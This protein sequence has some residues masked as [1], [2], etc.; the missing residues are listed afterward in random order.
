MTDE[1]FEG[2]PIVMNDPY[3]DVKPPERTDLVRGCPYC[4]SNATYLV[5]WKGRIRC[6]SCE[7][8]YDVDARLLIEPPK[9]VNETPYYLQPGYSGPMLKRHRQ[10][11]RGRRVGM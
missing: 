9:P 11:P 3:K 2:I 4:H 6:T 10:K 7:A 1:P 5:A 8:R